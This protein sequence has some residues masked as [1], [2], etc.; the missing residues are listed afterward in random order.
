MKPYLACYGALGIVL[1]ISTAQ[2]EPKIG[3]RYWHGDFAL[4]LRAGGGAGVVDGQVYGGAF[5]A[6]KIVVPGWSPFVG[7]GLHLS[8]GEVTVDDPRGIDGE[9]DVNRFAIGPEVRLGLARG[10]KLDSY[11]RAWPHVQFYLS[12]ALTSVHAGTLSTQLPEANHNWAFKFGAGVSL[13]LFWSLIASEKPES[14]LV[15]L[16]PNTYAFDMEVPSS[17]PT[18][19]RA[20]IRLGYGF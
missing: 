18:R 1:N 8:A 10:V 5:F 14:V 2:A 16:L 17:E 12:S 19:V 15:L 20:G 9:V 13:P 11:D 4:G 3:F 6:K 7:A